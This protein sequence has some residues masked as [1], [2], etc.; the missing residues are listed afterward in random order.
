MLELRGMLLFM[1]RRSLQKAMQKH[2]SR[3]HRPKMITSSDHQHCCKAG[4]KNTGEYSQNI[5]RDHFPP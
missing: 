5:S 4:N 2:Y 1:T 3:P